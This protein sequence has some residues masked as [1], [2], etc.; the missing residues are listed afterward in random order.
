MELN[1]GYSIKETRPEYY[2]NELLEKVLPINEIGQ[3]KKFI[4]IRESMRIDILEKVEFQET[5]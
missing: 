3:N 5:E 1:Y 4:R 2:E